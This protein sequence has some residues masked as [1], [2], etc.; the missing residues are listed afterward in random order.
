MFMLPE[1][2]GMSAVSLLWGLR[3]QQIYLSIFAG[4][5]QVVDK[6]HWTTWRST[7]ITKVEKGRDTARIAMC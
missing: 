5:M 1:A 6:R 3:W 4:F 7:K 2:I